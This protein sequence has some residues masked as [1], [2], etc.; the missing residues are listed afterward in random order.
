LS[1]LW[2]TYRVN[3]VNLELAPNNPGAG[4]QSGVFV[5]RDTGAAA[6][7]Y[8]LG[9]TALINRYST[10]KDVKLVAPARKAALAQAYGG[11]ML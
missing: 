3:R 7:P 9:A 4:N 6:L 10:L 1:K 2:L 11:L 8:P 5:V